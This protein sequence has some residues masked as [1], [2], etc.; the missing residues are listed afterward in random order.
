VSEGKTKFLPD[1]LIAVF[2]AE[3]GKDGKSLELVSI[4][5]VLAVGELD[6]VIEETARSSY[7]SRNPCY[8]V[9]QDICCKL[10]M[11]PEVVISSKT[12]VPE[13]GDLVLS[14]TRDSYKTDDPTEI[15]G[16]LYKIAYK[17]GNPT[18]ASLLIG[19]KMK[20]V[21]YASLVVLQKNK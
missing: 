3:S 20:E 2:G 16:I 10:S 18:T 19:T 17:F 14:Y 15:T 21:L 6:L 1:D 7:S 12:L 4:C 11:D 9:S 13:I 5:R 8:I